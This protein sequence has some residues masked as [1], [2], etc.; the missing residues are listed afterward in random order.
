MQTETELRGLMNSRSRAARALLAEKGSRS[1]TA[2]EQATFD[3]LVDDAEDAQ[4]QLQQAQGRGG[5]QSL[6][7]LPQREG[8]EIFLR[9]SAKAYT[10]E[11]R[12]KVSNAMS[13]TTGS[14]GGYSVGSLV[15]SEWV[16]TIKGYGWV[17]QVA[18]QITTDTGGAMKYPV[19]DGSAELGEVVAQNAVAVAADPTFAGRNLDAHKFSS[20]VFTVP[21]ELL[22]DAQID[23]VAVILQRARARIGRT[24]NIKFTVGTG[25]GEPTGLVPS[26]SVGKVGATGQVITIVYDDLVDIADTVDAQALGMP[27]ASQQGMLPGVGWMF[28]LTMRR[29]VRKVKDTTGRPIW[30]PGYL[31]AVDMS[32]P[33]LP[34]LLGYPVFINNDMPSP[35][36]SAKSLAFGNL[37]SYMVRDVAT[38]VLHR[39]DDSAFALK[40]QVGFLAFAR[41][42]GNLLDVNSVTLYQH[43]AT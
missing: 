34:L 7:A 36:A 14:E 29:V 13:T 30:T 22:Q 38:M 25:T 10:T 16:D 26:A 35:A 6:R 27:D 32:K 12:I 11:E 4:Q 40:G 1:W 23:I 24:Q 39:F 42:G 43:S 2:A 21:M 37:G 28:S 3:M 9:K 17:R 41:A 18:G 31:D 8:V 19:S 33:A 5:F 20:K 15:A